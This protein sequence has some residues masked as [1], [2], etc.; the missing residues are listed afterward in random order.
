M[1]TG[2]ITDLLEQ[3]KIKESEI[4]QKPSG[5]MLNVLKDEKIEALGQSIKDIQLL[6]QQRLLLNREILKDVEQIKLDINN[7][8]ASLGITSDSMGR[9]S[10]DSTIRRDILLLRQK[11]VEVDEA[12]VQEKL[13][14]WRDVAELK[15]E[16]RDQIKEYKEREARLHMLGSI[17]K[18]DENGAG[19]I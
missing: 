6:I 4:R 16:L 8:I 3:N 11:Q 15:K 7:H 18:G 17:L 10:G 9:G 19:I 5:E 12:K 1:E 2:F 13:N 14:C